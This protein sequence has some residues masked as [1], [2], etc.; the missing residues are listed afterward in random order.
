VNFA[1]LHLR[2][3]GGQRRL[4]VVDVTDRSDVDVRLVANELFFRH[5][6]ISLVT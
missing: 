2:D 5:V 1:G 3:R 4:A 6:A